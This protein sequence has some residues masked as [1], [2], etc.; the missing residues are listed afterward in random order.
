VVIWDLSL[1]VRAFEKVNGWYVVNR[2]GLRPRTAGANASAD[3]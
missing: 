1:I 3:A 2:D